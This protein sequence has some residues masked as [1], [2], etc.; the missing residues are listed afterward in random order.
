MTEFIIYCTTEKTASDPFIRRATAEYLHLP[1]TDWEILRGESGKPYHSDPHLPFF[2]LSHSGDY[3]VCAVGPAP[4]GVDVQVHSFHGKKREAETLLRLADR[5][6][7]PAEGSYLH[8]LSA[9]AVPE[10][11]FALWCAK[12]S[13]GKLTARGLR[14]FSDFRA[15]ALPPPA[16]V[17][18]LPLAAG[19]S[20]CL[21]AEGAF[22]CT[23]KWLNGA[24]PQS[25]TQ[26]NK[27]DV[28]NDQSTHGK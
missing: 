5:F 25:T 24:V 19:V 22:R 18:E 7:H 2:S 11:F 12:E 28:S 20:L 16:R 27:E 8:S 13:Y 14:G 26:T 10:A 23:V 6:F 21:A 17:R 15:N 4:C 9:D 3:T 1:L